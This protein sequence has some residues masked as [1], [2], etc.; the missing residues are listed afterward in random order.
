MDAEL[1]SKMLRG[2]LLE[3]DIVTLPGLGSF[4]TTNV[5]ATFSDRGFTI[6]P[7]YRKLEFTSGESGDTLLADLYAASNNVDRETGSAILKH[8][9]QEL[10]EAILAQRVISVPG[11]GRFR[12]ASDNSIFFLTDDDADI[13]PDC[14]G[15]QPISLKNHTIY[16][17]EPVRTN[18][19]PKE[20][21]TRAG[22]TEEVR[23]AEPGPAAKK[24]KKCRWWRW[25][26][27]LLITAVI[28][29]AAYLLI[30]YSAPDLLDSILYTPEE[31][32]IIN[33]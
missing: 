8:Y 13:N 7:P 9:L 22:K 1:L 16:T 2:L 29:L 33:Y 14:F 17:A 6:N 32:R 23:V 28:A 3:N 5:P 10:K 18:P 25:V 12:V 27:A 31:L 4:V 15:L 24:K 19:L 11:L 20:D 26:I 30:A 21:F